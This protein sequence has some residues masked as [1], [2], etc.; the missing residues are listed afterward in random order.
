MEV[1]LVPSEAILDDIH[2][3]LAHCVT[4]CVPYKTHRINL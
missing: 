3:Y 1:Q 4:E 2:I